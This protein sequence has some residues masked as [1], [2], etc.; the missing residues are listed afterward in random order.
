MQLLPVI[1]AA[2][3]TWYKP[4][5]VSIFIIWSINVFAVLFVAL[6]ERGS[7]HARYFSIEINTPFTLHKE[8][9]RTEAE[10]INDKNSC[11]E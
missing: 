3:I 6:N 4:M 10:S 2:L 11:P 1:F 5:G 7:V 9:N 8:V